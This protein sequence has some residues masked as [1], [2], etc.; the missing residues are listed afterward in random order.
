[1]KVDD[2]IVTQR[3][4]WQFDETV[5]PGFVDHIRRSVPRYDDGHDIVCQ[6]SDYF[7]LND[8]ICYELGCSTGELTAKLAAHNSHKP[9]IR[10]IAIDNQPS[11]LAEAEKR[12]TDQQNIKFVCE[13]VMDTEF[14]KADFI[15]A[16]YTIQFITP[17]NRQVLI[18]RIYQALNW[19]GAFI[20]FEK[21]RGPDARFQDIMTNLYFNFKKSNGFSAEEILNKYDSLKSVLEPFSTEGNL[22]L[23]Q[24]A[25][26]VDVVTI[27]KHICFEGFL[28]IK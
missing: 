25:G 13:S 4:N 17:R 6:L 10:W 28:A 15:V 14:G 24:R 5:A 26:F 2:G 21:V 23:L 1:M 7:C 12:C 8:S 18:D 20:M 3:A 19:G 16:Y 11:M 27:F 22:G 9:K